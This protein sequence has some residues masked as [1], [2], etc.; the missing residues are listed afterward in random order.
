MGR[1]L[2][3]LFCFRT[4]VISLTILPIFPCFSK[5]PSKLQSK[6]NELLKKWSSCLFS[7]PPP[8]RMNCRRRLTFLL[9]LASRSYNTD[10]SVEGMLYGALIPAAYR[11]PWAAQLPAFCYLLLRKISGDR[12]FT[13]VVPSKLGTVGLNPGCLTLLMTLATATFDSE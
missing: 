11:Q 2:L 13:M 5:L 7:P 8:H 1:V 6:E 9:T 10:G 12:T 4:Q 3:E